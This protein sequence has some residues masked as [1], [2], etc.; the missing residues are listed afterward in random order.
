[1]SPVGA[2]SRRH[3][4]RG[5]TVRGQSLVEFALV[6]PIFVAT[7]LGLIDV[8][9]FVYLNSTLSQA[10][11]EAARVGSVEASYV[12][13]SDS[14]CGRSG[15]PVC[16]SN[17]AALVSDMQSAANRMMNPFGSV[18]HVYIS[19][20]SSSG[21]PPTGSWTS[22]TCSSNSSGSMISVRVTEQFT[23]LTPIASQLVGISLSGTATM[24]IN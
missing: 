21:T 6:I 11:R 12:G 9:R 2:R 5:R 17:N 13:S 23:P 24:A 19:C 22:S 1:M 4:G 15:G 8:A 14:T 10:A 7:L 16:P 3:A 18:D 20:V